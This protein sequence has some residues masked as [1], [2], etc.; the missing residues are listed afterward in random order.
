MLT[1][2]LELQL[3][4]HD[5]PHAEF[6]ISSGEGTSSADKGACAHVGQ[7]LHGATNRVHCS[8]HTLNSVA[9]SGEETLSADTGGCHSLLTL[10][11]VDL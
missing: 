4:R 11:R 1:S 10:V 8:S 9:G 3:G 7:G 5:R 2:T 6:A